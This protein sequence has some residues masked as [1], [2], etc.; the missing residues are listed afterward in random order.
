MPA[1]PAVVALKLVRGALGTCPFAPCCRAVKMESRHTKYKQTDGRADGR[2]AAR[3]PRRTP[4]AAASQGSSSAPLRAAEGRGLSTGASFILAPPPLLLVSLR[5]HSARIASCRREVG[6]K[7]DL[8][9]VSQPTAHSS[10]QH[11]TRV[12]S[13]PRANRWPVAAQIAE[14]A[15][16]TVEP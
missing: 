8:W 7:R 2:L 9:T 4:A 15:P 11:H 5:A 10:R 14:P 1:E 6:T 3:R 12:R 13:N 16:P